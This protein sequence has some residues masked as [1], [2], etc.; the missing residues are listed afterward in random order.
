MHSVIVIVG[1]GH[2]LVVTRE[3][4]QDAGGVANRC[5]QGAVAAQ[6]AE[7]WRERQMTDVVLV[8]S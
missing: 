2:C 1:D 4:G 3:R 8:R 5:L 7:L 6:L